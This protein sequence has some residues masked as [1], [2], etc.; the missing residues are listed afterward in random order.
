MTKCLNCGV[1]NPPSKSNKPRKYCSKKCANTYLYNIEA[2]KNPNSKNPN[3]KK[4]T[5]LEKQKR[6]ERKALY[7]WYCENRWSPKRIAE[8]FNMV[9]ATVWAKS[10]A[11]DI[12]GEMIMWS[13][14]KLFFTEEQAKRIVTEEIGPNHDNAFL[15]KRRADAI[16]RGK[17]RD[18]D[19]MRSY[20]QR[21]EVKAR[22]AKYR[23]DKK[24][25]NPAYRLRCNV[26]ALIYDAL[27]RKQG[28][29]KGGSTFEHLPYTPLELKEHIESQFDEHMSWDNYGDYWQLDH[30]TPQAALIYDSLKHPNFQKCWAL[31]NLQP[32]A[33]HENASKGSFWNGKRYFYKNN[34]LTN[35]TS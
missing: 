17:R 24:K 4:K 35:S 9:A 32:L 29:T 20:R 2:S 30:I 26:S 11:L 23:R 34:K 27:V 7:E 19:S 28:L 18:P 13:G 25:R 10:K 1:K 12:E 8:E 16:E 15:R 22:C 14:K 31:D 6:A 3:W 21:P 33:K 5:I